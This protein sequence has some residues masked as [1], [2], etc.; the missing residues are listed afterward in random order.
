[1]RSCQGGPNAGMARAR[2]DVNN[3]FI[4]KLHSEAELP[5]SAQKAYAGVP[6]VAC[7][8]TSP[9]LFALTCTLF[10]LTCS[11]L[12]RACVPILPIPCLH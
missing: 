7:M 6:M 1:M 12:H 2:S 10:S 5:S 11:M 8:N 9:S 4:S 3:V